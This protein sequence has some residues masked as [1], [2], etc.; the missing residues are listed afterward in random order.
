MSLTSPFPYIGG[1]RRW[2]ELVWQY[3]GEPTVYSEPFAG[4]LAVLLH[5][6]T[7][8]QREVV[9]DKNGFIANFWRALREDP[10][11][12]GVLGRLSNVSPGPDGSACWL[13]DWGNEHGAI[14]MQDAEWYDVKAAGWWCWGMSNWIGSGFDHGTD[15]YGGNISDSIPFC[16]RSVGG[17]GV[18]VQRTSLGDKIPLMAAVNTRGRGVSVQKVSMPF[19]GGIGAGHRLI[20]MMR[21][22]AQRLARVIVLAR[23]WESVV[24][25]TVLMDTRTSAK[26]P[27]AVFLDP[28]IPG[29]HPKQSALC[30]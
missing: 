6:K 25:P 18:Q 15:G 24:T 3:F 19:E 7:P 5:R 28:P 14:L 29:G 26:P 22:L 30:V 13:H 2:A 12:C 9:T 20:P 23:D 1:K 8:C 11:G 10:E 4:S 27:V 16:G 21:A 17:Q